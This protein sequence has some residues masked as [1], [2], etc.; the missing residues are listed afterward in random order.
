M[1]A[2]LRRWLGVDDVP[3][4]KP[5][6]APVQRSPLLIRTAARPA[7]LPNNAEEPP[8][9]PLIVSSFRQLCSLYSCVTPKFVSVPLHFRFSVDCDDVRRGMVKFSQPLSLVD[10]SQAQVL[11][12]R[13]AI[14]DKTAY[15]CAVEIEKY[16]TGNMQFPVQLSLRLDHRV[17]EWERRREQRTFVRQGRASPTI[18]SM[19]DVV[20]P[21]HP[22]CVHPETTLLMRGPCI[23]SDPLSGVQ[24][25]SL[26]A[27][28]FSTTHLFT[29]V[30]QRVSGD[31]PLVRQLSLLFHDECSDDD[32]IFYLVSTDYAYCSLLERVHLFLALSEYESHS[33]LREPFEAVDSA[34]FKLPFSMQSVVFR[35][36]RL[37]T[38]ANFIEQTLAHRHPTVEPLRIEASCTPFAH[39]SWLEAW[40]RRVAVHS[41]NGASTKKVGKERRVSAAQECVTHEQLDVEQQVE[42]SFDVTVTVHCALLPTND[43]PR[44]KEKTKYREIESII[45]N[46]NATSLATADSDI[47]NG[48]SS[49]GDD[50]PTSMTCFE[51]TT[52]DEE[53]DS[54]TMIDHARS[55]SMPIL[56]GAAEID[57]S[58]SSPYTFAWSP[59]LL[60]SPAIT[61]KNVL[62]ANRFFV[63]DKALFDEPAPPSASHSAEYDSGDIELVEKKTRASS[64]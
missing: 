28:N 11:T 64:Q 62:S 4:R 23:L 14:E 17:D 38:V 19:R 21:Q 58:G 12:R 33:S 25:G 18:Y 39:R 27:L 45:N 60:S 50:S 59:R 6:A 63:A 49:S 40:Q 51:T 1:S 32:S 31:S 26:E 48:G 55:E 15:V 20:L 16:D 43:G 9:P 53:E 36:S 61:P 44:K 54:S 24:I 2:N 13:A 22:K 7:A 47:C 29:N 57:A 52:A 30:A 56:N 8:E 34:L 41:S 37:T 10:K 42:F 46:S 35:A 3:R 5:S